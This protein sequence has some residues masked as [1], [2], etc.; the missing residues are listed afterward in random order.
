MTLT[1]A[2]IADFADRFF[3][4]RMAELEIP[5]AAVVVVRGEELLFANGYGWADIDRQIAIDPDRTVFRVGSISKLVTATAIMQLVEARQLDLFTEIDRYLTDVRV[6][7]AFNR[8]ICTADLLTHTAGFD[9]HSI[10]LETLD[11][12]QLIPLGEYFARRLPPRVRPPGRTISYSNHGMGLAGHLVE[13]V[14]GMSF[15]DYVRAHIFQPLAMHQSSFDLSDE[16]AANLAVGYEGAAP[17]FRSVPFSYIKIPPGGALVTT[18]TDLS[19]LMMAHLQQGRYKNT[20]ILSESTAARMHRQQFTNHPHIPG[21]C[22]GF[23]EQFENGCRAIVHGGT[24]RGFVSLFYLLPEANIGF[25]VTANSLEFSLMTQLV[26]EFLDRF[27]PGINP[28]LSTPYTQKHQLDPAIYTGYY[29]SYGTAR[30]TVQKISSL[31]S[32]VCV[33]SNGT[34]L[35]VPRLSDSEADK[36]LPW[37][38]VE[39]MLFQQ[40]DRDGYLA[41]R[42][43]DTDRSILM[44]RDLGVFEKLAWWQSQPLHFGIAIFFLLF[45]AIGCAW[46]SQLVAIGLPE[47]T[48][49]LAILIA[50]LNVLFPISFIIA[51]SNPNELIYGISRLLRAILVIPILT[52]ILTIGLVV[53]TAIAWI[54]GDL[55]LW[56]QLYYSIVAIVSIGFSLWLNYWNLFGFRV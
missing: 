13:A 55:N 21:F 30:T 38:A 48:R 39:P 22:Y 36:D 49:V 27:Y 24:V 8:P 16:L 31:F 23:Y 52:A 28:P 1:Q 37:V 12:S 44:F 19:H 7:T 53:V 45:F 43:D 6:P 3:E 29:R 18:A 11:R 50:G 35:I 54:N 17:K 14:S 32:Q 41:F 26:S 25:V 46:L 34:D 2:E 5:G 47:I 4:Q 10:G 15:E 56:L 42:Q 9:E 40:P 33:S 20:R 51:A